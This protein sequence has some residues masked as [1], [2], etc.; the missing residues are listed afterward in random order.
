[1]DFHWKET[2]DTLQFD[3]YIQLAGK[4]RAQSVILDIYLPD[5]QKILFTPQTLKYLRKQ[6]NNHWQI[7]AIQNQNKNLFIMQDKALQAI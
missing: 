2:N 5:K 7:R 3:N 4:W 1:M 6:R